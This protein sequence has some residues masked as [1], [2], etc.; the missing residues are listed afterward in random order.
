MAVV[1]VELDHAYLV[2]ADQEIALPLT[3][4]K[5]S[6]NKDLVFEVK[7]DGGYQIDKVVAKSKADGTERPLEPQADGSYRLAASEVSS[8]LVI[9]PVVALAPE[10]DGAVDDAGGPLRNLPRT[11]WPTAAI[12][13]SKHRSLRRTAMPQHRLALT[14]LSELK[15]SAFLPSLP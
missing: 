1:G 2:V 10:L 12:R 5:T 3:S 4:F 8:N 11:N 9:K 13:V 7:P 6:L 14:T 15:P